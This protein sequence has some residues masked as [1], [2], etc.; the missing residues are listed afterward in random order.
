MPKINGLK[1]QPKIDAL[2][3]LT[4]DVQKAQ[5]KELKDRNNVYDMLTSGSFSKAGSARQILSMPGVLLDIKGNPIEVPVH[6]S[7]GEGIDTPSYWNSLYAVRKGTVDRSVNTMDSGALN[8]SL[9]AV[10]R[11]L[12]IVE[13]DCKTHKGLDFLIDSKDVMDRLSAETIP[14]VIV[15]NTIVDSQILLLLKMKGI[16]E[17]KVRSPLTCESSNGICSNCYGLLPNGE[18]P[19][20]GENVGV[21]E[22]QALTERSTQLTMQTFHS[23]GDA[24]AGGGILGGFPR[25]LQLLEVPA[26][27][28]N[29]A[30]LSDVK[31]SVKTIRKNPIGGYELRIEGYGIQN[32]KTFSI[33][34]NS[35]IKV[36]IGDKVNIGDALTEGPIKPQE[37]GALTSHL[38]AQRYIVDEIND[39][40]NNDF[41]KKTFETVVRAI[42][43]FATIDSAP[44]DVDFER[45][46]KTSKSY[47]ESLNKGR[48]EE[49][50]EPI[51]Y[52][53]YFKSIETSNVDNEDWLTKFTTNRIKS[54]VQEAASSASYADIAGK[55]PIPAYIYGDTF[56][57]QRYY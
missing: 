39:V 5:D 45:G 52:T 42:S 7:Y 54:A 21:S 18:L 50:L 26:N 55:D 57:K 25:T 40:Y 30:V 13:E 37:L 23:G 19:S 31:G 35:I 2:N 16:K 14:N 6:K 41:N 11:R 10:T 44:N 29:K 46:D 36:K 3:Q 51:Q 33:P 24:L 43:D 1:G 15:K 12:I 22:G 20:I 32:D 48:I 4:L 9:L 47:I 8:K 28:A 38:D 17:L 34:P 53:P 56:G 49:G 27:L